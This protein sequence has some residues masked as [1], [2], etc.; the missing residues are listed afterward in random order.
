MMRKLTHLMQLAVPFTIH[1]VVAD[2]FGLLEVVVISQF[3]GNDALAAYFATFFVLTLSTMVTTGAMSSLTLLCSPAIATQ[4]WK[5]AGHY[6]QIAV[7]LRTVAFLPMMAIWW[8]YLPHVVY[9]LGFDDTVVDIAVLYAIPVFLYE[10]VSP[11][12]EG[13]HYILDVAGLERYSAISNGISSLVSLAG[14]F[15]M[16]FAVERGALPLFDDL[17]LWLVGAWH[18]GLLVLCILIDVAVIVH[19]QWFPIELWKGFFWSLPSGRACKTF[20]KASVP[21]A[22]S[23]VMEYCEWELLFVFAAVQGP[24]EVE[25]WGLLGLLWG[26]AEDMAMALADAAEVRVA[27]LLGQNQPEVAKYCAHKAT[28]W[29]SLSALF[30]AVLMAALQNLLAR[31]MTKDETLQSLVQSLLPMVAIGLCL[32]TLGTMSWSILCAQ[33]RVRLATV[34]IFISSLFCTLPLACLSTFYFGF[35]LQ[36][37]LA[38]V[39]MGYATAGA[40]NAFFMCHSN[41]SKVADKVSKRTFKNEKTKK[42][43]APYCYYSATTTNNNRHGVRR[44]ILGRIAL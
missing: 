7:L 26:V 9:W 25:A 39:I 37:L 13:L 27:Q 5:L 18:V 40:M 3:F 15:G 19:F 12:H 28:F 10:F 20:F 11:F 24:A 17:E 29:C 31:L 43:K 34:N 4:R 35:N 14:T 32:L 21:L 16:V 1:A 42:L 44:K 6:V 2:V 22:A 30:M 38:A 36:G 41:W 23:Y 33:G 8:T